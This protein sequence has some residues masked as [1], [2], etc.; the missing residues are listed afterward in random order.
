MYIQMMDIDS[1][2][3]DINN[4]LHE[5]GA[6]ELD[7]FGDIIKDVKKDSPEFKMFEYI[8]IDSDSCDIIVD[9]EVVKE[10]FNYIRDNFDYVELGKLMGKLKDEG[11]EGILLDIIQLQSLKNNSYFDRILNKAERVDK[12]NIEVMREFAKNPEYY[13]RIQLEVNRISKEIFGASDSSFKKNAPENHV[14]KSIA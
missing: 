12:H 3:R 14:D 5:L 2:M 9:I 7:V 13:A 6:Y 4:T 8:D 1:I 11:V 10:V